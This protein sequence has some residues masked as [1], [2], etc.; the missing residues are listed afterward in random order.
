MGRWAMSLWQFPV[1]LYTQECCHTQVIKT[2]KS[3]VKSVHW[4]YLIQDGLPPPFSSACWLRCLFSKKAQRLVKLQGGQQT[5]DSILPLRALPSYPDS[6]KEWQW[7]VMMSGR[8][9]LTGQ[10][11]KQYCASSSFSSIL[12]WGRRWGI[13]MFYS[14]MGGKIPGVIGRIGGMVF[15]QS[16]WK[17]LPPK[18]SSDPHTHVHTA[19]CPNPTQ[20]Q[21]YAFTQIINTMAASCNKRGI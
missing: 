13:F 18:L 2:S 1:C 20:P 17:C 5:N 19:T 11:V 8:S 16:Q 6:Q 7:E 12:S 15:A 9:D 21:T 10:H 3:V 14:R 4:C